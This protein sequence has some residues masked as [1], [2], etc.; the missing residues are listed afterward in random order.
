[1]FQ[2]SVLYLLNNLNDKTS[3]F[4]HYLH[5]FCS[6]KLRNSSI[7][8][9]TCTLFQF[10]GRKIAAMAFNLHDLFIIVLEGRMIS[11][12]FQLHSYSSSSLGTVLT[13][14]LWQCWTGWRD[15][16]WVG[17]P[18]GFLIR[19]R[20]TIREVRLYLQLQSTDTE[21]QRHE[22]AMFVG[23]IVAWVKSAYTLASNTV[24]HDR[25]FSPYI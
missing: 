9:H 13:L 11:F 20:R 16:A 6:T 23:C 2:F 25:S 24:S 17:S 1:M 10:P 3:H 4:K 18:D 7:F 15:W 8:T 22:H 12:S 19:R 21:T 14:L 5:V